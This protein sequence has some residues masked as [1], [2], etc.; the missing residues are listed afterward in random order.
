MNTSLWTWAGVRSGVREETDSS[1]LRV[2]QH[3]SEI[4]ALTKQCRSHIGLKQTDWQL[5]EAE[6]IIFFVSNAAVFFNQTSYVFHAIWIQ[7]S[8]ETP[9]DFFSVM[10]HFIRFVIKLLH[11]WFGIKQQIRTLLSTETSC[12]LTFLCILDPVWQLPGEKHPF[13][14]LNAVLS[15]DIQQYSLAHI[16]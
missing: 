11:N 6:Q 9:V 12:P 1:H 7:S 8:E 10:F 3:L 2:Y 13:T 15:L 4:L 14:I 16:T 5:K